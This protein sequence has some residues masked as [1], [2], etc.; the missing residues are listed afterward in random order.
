MNKPVMSLA[1]LKTEKEVEHFLSTAD[2][3]IQ[4]ELSYRTER[5]SLPVLKK[6]LAGRVASVHACCPQTEFFPNLASSNPSVLDQSM[7]DLRETLQ[8]AKEFAAE[9]VVLHTGYVTDKAMPSKFSERKKLLETEEFSKHTVD[10]KTSICSPEYIQ[11]PEYK[12]FSKTAC[13][14]LALIAKEYKQNGILLAAENLNPRVSYLFQTPEEMIML[15]NY[16]KDIYLC[17]D[18]GHLWI[19]S[20][21]FNFDFFEGIKK[22]LDTGKVISCHL[23]SNCSDGVILEDSHHSIDKYNF[24]YKKIISLLQTTNTNIVLEVVEEFERNANLLLDVL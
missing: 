24:P 12:A 6:L 17:L 22:I 15:A 14:Q 16:H 9:L 1:G 3:C 11:T 8:V 5:K 23:H 21:V 2:S 19:A 4:F 13:E 10:S 18:V 7:Q 20:F